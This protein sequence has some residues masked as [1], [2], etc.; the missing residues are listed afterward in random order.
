MTDTNALHDVSA[1]TIL[2]LCMI[3][4]NVSQGR[5]VVKDH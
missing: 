4:T 1:C 2:I 3:Y 5:L